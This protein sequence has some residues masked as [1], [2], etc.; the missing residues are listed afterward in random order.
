MSRR[1]RALLLCTLGLAILG[2]C[3]A[4]AQAPVVMMTS[5]Q[6]HDRQMQLLKISG[7]PAGPDAYQAATYNEATATPYPALPDP[8]VMNDGT[9]V[10]TP[11]QWAKRRAEIK[12]FFDREVYGRVPAEMPTVRWDVVSSEKAVP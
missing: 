7:F 1:R 12:E 8:L 9:R 10:T 4:Q 2:L 5:Q 11:A 6:D 3:A